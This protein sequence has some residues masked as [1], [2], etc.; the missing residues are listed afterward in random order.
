MLSSILFWIA[1]I[2]AVL[3]Y[4]DARRRWL[5]YPLCWAGAVFGFWIVAL[6]VYVW[7]RKKGRQF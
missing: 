5:N 6:P 7:I 4:R 1:L 2:S 3:V